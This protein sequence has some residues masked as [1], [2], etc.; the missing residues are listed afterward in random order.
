ME[1]RE[2]GRTGMKVSVLGLGLAEIPLHSDS[3]GDVDLAW[4][5][6]NN[7]L[8]H[9]INFLDTAACYGE[10]EEMIGGTVSHRRDKL[11]LAT[12]AGH[13]T[14]GASGEPWTARVIAESIDR[15][16]RRLRTD[17]LDLV[18]V[19]TCPLVVLRGGGEGADRGPG[20]GQRRWQDSLHRLQRGQRGR[21][22]GRR[23]RLVRHTPDELQPGRPAG[24]HQRAVR[25][26]RVPSSGSHRQAAGSQRSLG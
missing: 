3:S 11:Y 21:P 19:H 22:M 14:G 6:L 25:G 4:L 1:M 7:A 24:S 2:L 26:S 15:S 9:G 8:D 12:K 13:V 17:H 20:A 5:V 16:L 23:E 18:Q 10:T